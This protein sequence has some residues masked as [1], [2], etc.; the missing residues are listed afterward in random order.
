[1]STQ[2][3]T[4]VQTNSILVDG[5]TGYI[6][7]HLVHYLTR[8][9][10]DKQKIRCLV[11]TKANSSDVDFLRSSGAS[12]FEADLNETA[13]DNIFSQVDVACHL[14]GSIAPPKGES[15]ETLHI[16]QTERFVQQ[17]VRSKVKKIIMVSA[18]GAE[19]NAKSDYHRTKWQAERIILESGIPSLILRPSLVIGKTQGTRNSKL[20]ARLENLIRNKKLVPL[21]KGGSNKVQPI[22][23]NDLIEAISASFSINNFAGP[24]GSIVELGG[25]EILSLKQLVQ[26]IMNKIGIERPILALPLP[27]ASIAAQIALLT[28][29]VPVISPD[30][31]K[32][33]LKDNICHNNGLKSLIGRNPTTLEAALDSYQWQV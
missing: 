30:Q 5:A 20:I 16:G 10:D 18:C 17:C 15:S 22:F 13:L 6:G 33:A 8:S 25:P 3:Y 7:S 9:I 12:L 2:P 31:I 24:D 1:M 29:E 4:L 14:I 32:I 19:P 11:R 26:K 23:I 21:I 28:Q 27:I